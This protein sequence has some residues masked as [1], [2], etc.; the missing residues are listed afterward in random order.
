MFWSVCFLAARVAGV[1]GVQVG[2][3]GRRSE[4]CGSFLR[5]AHG[6]GDRGGQ[7]RP[8]T[9]NRVRSVGAPPSARRAPAGEHLV[10]T[11]P[12][13]GRRTLP[14]AS[15]SLL[16]YVSNFVTR[17]C[18]RGHRFLLPQR[19]L[20]TFKSWFKKSDHFRCIRGV[21]LNVGKGCGVG[22]GVPDLG[23]DPGR[24]P[25][26]GRSGSGVWAWSARS[27]WGSTQ[28]RSFFAEA[29]ALGFLP[30]LPPTASAEDWKQP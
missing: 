9:Q 11:F 3:G 17:D 13:R 30:D 25:G 2:V 4:A 14:G 16:R 21:R 10:V 20:H 28:A 19:R 26:S 27:L 8:R 22:W 15:H 23:C 1:E 6:Q 5:T 18:I 7:G 12:A 29:G 24:P